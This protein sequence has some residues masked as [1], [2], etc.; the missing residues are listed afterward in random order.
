MPSRN[1]NNISSNIQLIPE[2]YANRCIAEKLSEMLAKHLGYTPRVVHSYKY[3]RD[4]IIR[5]IMKRSQMGQRFIALI[6]YERGVSRVYIDRHFELEEI[7]ANIFIGVS[8]RSPDA[9]AVVFDPDIESAFLCMVSR[10][11]CESPSRLRRVKS[12]DACGIVGRLLEE[13]REGV[14]FMQRLVNGILGRLSIQR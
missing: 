6:D 2:C 3:G 7:E 10:E 8:R 11:L 14:R 12:R 4:R 9:I 5:E 13:Y 1:S